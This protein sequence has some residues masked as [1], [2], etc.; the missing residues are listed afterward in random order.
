MERT[1]RRSPS[2]PE[3]EWTPTLNGTLRIRGNDPRRCADEVPKHLKT[4]NPPPPPP[5][6]SPILA[7]PSNWSMKEYYWNCTGTGHNIHQCPENMQLGSKV[8]NKMPLQKE[9]P[10]NINHKT[11]I[12]CSKCQQ[13]GHNR[14]TCTSTN[15]LQ[16][17][18]A[19]CSYCKGHHGLKRY[20][21]RENDL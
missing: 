3:N 9:K 21:K 20:K 12:K 14:R 11:K 2:P 18:I 5:P 7:G 17:H 16:N 19:K 1:I 8:S 13:Q 6:T 15:D 4:H 10:S